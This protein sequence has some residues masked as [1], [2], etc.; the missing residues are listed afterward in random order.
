MFSVLGHGSEIYG[1]T[2]TS[3]PA[4]EPVS[5][6]EAKQHLRV[7][8]A[9]DDT[10]IGSLITAARMMC[11][12][13]LN[14]S[15]VTQSWRLTLDR[16]PCEGVIHVPRTPLQSVTSIT[17]KDVAGNTQ[18]MSSTLYDVDVASRP[19]RIAPSYNTFWPVT[20][21]FLWPV[22]R[23]Q[24]AAVQVTFVAGYGDASAVP[25]QV[26]LAIKMMVGSWYENREAVVVGQTGS[27]LPMAVQAL[28]MSVWA[29]TY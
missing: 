16:F 22:S 27:E 11:E 28:L 10:L 18:T 5:L 13:Q 3:A 14:Q 7:D 6:A 29:G 17:Y 26:K 19:G 20:Y 4:T 1:L 9:D 8:F 15:F 21:G 12:S 25:E 23:A 24:I 2:L